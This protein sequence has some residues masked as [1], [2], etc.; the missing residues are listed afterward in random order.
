MVRHGQSE[1]FLAVVLCV[2]PALAGGE[3]GG[4]GG[5]GD[6]VQGITG[7][8]APHGDGRDERSDTTVRANDRYDW[9]VAEYVEL[10][11]RNGYPCLIGYTYHDAGEGL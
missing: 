3:V 8:S 4:C 1:S 11:E 2:P 9:M 7:R 5:P 6:K 10:A